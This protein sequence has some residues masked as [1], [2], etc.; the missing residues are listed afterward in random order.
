MA[1]QNLSRG[2]ERR[3]RGREGVIWYYY[4]QC[5]LQSLSSTYQSLSNPWSLRKQLEGLM[6]RFFWRGSGAGEDSAGHVRCG[7]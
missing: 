1:S 3:R 7:L 4:N 2:E 5:V 6:R